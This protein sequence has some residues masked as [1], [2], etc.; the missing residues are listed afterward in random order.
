[1]FHTIIT[2]AYTIPNI[3]VFLRIW[4]IFINKG[5]KI[6]FTVIYVLLASIYP[7]SNIIDKGDSL[8]QVRILD[9][10][11]NYLVPFY[12]YLFL[13]VL[14]LDVLLLINRLFKI[15]PVEKIRSNKFKKTGLSLLLLIPVSVVIAGII[16][17]NTI[18]ISEYQIDVPAGSSELQNLRI[19]FVADF[20]LKE[21]TNIAFVRRF[22]EKIISIKPDLMLFGGDIVDDDREN[23]KMIL[24]E[25]LLNVI[26]ARY[27][28]WAVM[29][30]HEHYSGHEKGTFFDKAGITMLRDTVVIVNNS[31]SL[32]GRN[33][34]HVRGRKSIYEIMEAVTDSLPVIVLD[35]RPTE[36]E[37][38]SKTSAD[39]QLSGHTHNGQLFP[40]NFI[41]R[42]FYTLSWGYMKSGNTHFF[43]TSG[44]RLWGPLVRT[45]GKSEIMLIDIKFINSEKAL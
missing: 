40:I 12:L 18:R 39:V 43:V 30:N 20:H 28:S 11:G 26:N 34:S 23:E 9:L 37:E 21:E 10:A 17:F 7:L 5:Y 1:M 22:V 16:N 44:L 13:S 35:H 41:T 31:F 38:V 8:F 24:F 3:Y 6:L 2:L 27:G 36:I 45:T 29:G 4:Q 14:V 15:I 19:A 33:D 32:A 25:K 42:R